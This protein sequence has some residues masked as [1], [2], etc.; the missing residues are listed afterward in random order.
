[1]RTTKE[2]RGI[3]SCGGYADT[4]SGEADGDVTKD[5]MSWIAS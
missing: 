1:M 4:C 2:E 3:G 5:I